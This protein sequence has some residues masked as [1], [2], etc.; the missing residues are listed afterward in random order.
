MAPVRID[1]PGKMSEE[2]EVP[3]R[4]ASLTFTIEHILSL[5]QQDA[6]S[7]GRRRDGAARG[8]DHWDGRSGFDSGAEH[9]GGP[10]GESD[11]LQKH[12]THRTYLFLPACNKIIGNFTK[13][14]VLSNGS[15]F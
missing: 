8:D 1:M 4:G 5:K 7:G 9:T 14:V 2:E 10:T 6:S 11:E 15:G 3:T 13:N 12:F